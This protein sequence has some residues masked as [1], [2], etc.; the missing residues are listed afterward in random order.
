MRD[1][2]VPASQDPDMRADESALRGGEI[3]GQ[4]NWLLFNDEDV[5]PDR[6]RKEQHRRQQ[7]QARQRERRG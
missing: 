1:V 6:K 2:V 7:R 4:T 5:Q 3:N